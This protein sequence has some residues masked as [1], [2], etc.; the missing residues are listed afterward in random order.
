MQFNFRQ[1]RVFLIFFAISAAFYIKGCGSQFVDD[2][3][4]LFVYFRQQGWAGFFDSFGFTSLYYGHNLINLIAYSLFGMN[5]LAW[6]LLFTGMHSLNAFLGFT[7]FSRLFQNNNL[8]HAN[9]I[10]LT[11]SLL[12][13]LGPHQ[14]ENVIWGATLHYAVSF[15][16]LWLCLILQAAHFESGKLLPLFLSH[17]LFAFALVTL[18]LSLVFPAIFFIVFSFLWTPW[19]EF[20]RMKQVIS[21][22]MVPNIFLI[23]IYFLLT[24]I[25]KGNYIGH[26]GSDVHLANLDLFSLTS[27]FSKYIVK[28]VFFIHH[29]SY[30][31]RSAVYEFIASHQ[32]IS[33]T[34]FFLLI[35]ISVIS[36]VFSRRKAVLIACL[37]LISF[38]VL[39][40]ALNMYF[41]YLSSTENERLSYM[42]SYFIYM[43]VALL[44]SA[45][46]KAGLIVFSAAFLATSVYLVQESAESWKGASEV[47]SLSVNSFKWEGYDNIFVLNQP[48]YFRG[49]YVFRNKKRLNRAL[50][51][52]RDIDYETNIEEVA[53]T[54][55]NSPEDSV[56]VEK[57]SELS[58]KVSLPAWGRWF[59]YNNYGAVDYENEHYEVDFADDSQSYV[60]KFKKL[61]QS[62][63][64][65][66]YTSSGWR[67]VR[68]Q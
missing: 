43:A 23:L 39:L 53:W 9:L 5:R 33:V 29:F 47:Q 3:F 65:I 66:Y 24:K 14:T 68:H 16:C 30:G 6:F 7:F 26:Y 56:A 34:A 57:L 60:V 36:F 4:T 51:V 2:Y 45:A 28:L 46:G 42:A 58:F 20:S 12:F 59:W 54:T 35:I 18:E 67:E 21:R 15:G 8:R 25:M 61:S 55:I 44:F 37:F 19:F 27:A 50:F 22:I 10:A 49:V 52:M 40:P 62:D 32:V 64:I 11:G 17:L 13:L 48:C 31:T 63:V 1:S 38:I 41:A